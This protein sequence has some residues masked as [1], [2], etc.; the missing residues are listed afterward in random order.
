[1]AAFSFLFGAL[2]GAGLGYVVGWNN[3]RHPG[4][5][6]AQL[7]AAWAKVTHKEPKV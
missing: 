2:L 4:K 5:I 6:K 7:A 3:A 1:M